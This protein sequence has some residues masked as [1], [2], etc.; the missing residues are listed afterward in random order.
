MELLNKLRALFKSEPEE[1]LDM[2][3]YSDDTFMNAVAELAHKRTREEQA[4]RQG[5][6]E[7]QQLNQQQA[8]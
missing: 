4:A 8:A 3:M 1:V 2:P 6:S 5:G 7:S